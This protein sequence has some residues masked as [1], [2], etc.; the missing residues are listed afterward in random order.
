MIPKVKTTQS[1]DEINV[2]INISVCLWHFLHVQL[3]KGSFI[4]F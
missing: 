2:K 1:E 4:Y 3:F